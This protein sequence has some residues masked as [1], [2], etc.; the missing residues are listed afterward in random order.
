MPQKKELN[1]KD[2][3]VACQLEYLYRR[4]HW[5]QAI[6]VALTGIRHDCVIRTSTS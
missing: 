1:E 4:H 2:V 3:T 5:R 6:S